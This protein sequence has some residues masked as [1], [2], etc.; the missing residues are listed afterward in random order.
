MDPSQSPSSPVAVGRHLDLRE[1]LGAQLPKLSREDVERVYGSPATLHFDAADLMGRIDTWERAQGRAPEDSASSGTV[2]GFLRAEAL[3]GASTV[4]YNCTSREE[5]GGRRVAWFVPGHTG[6]AALSGS[7]AAAIKSGP[8][9]QLQAIPRVLR[10]AFRA[11]PGRVLVDVDL[12]SAF[13]AAA[14]AVTRDPQLTEDV[15]L[16][17]HQ[18]VGDL[19][20]GSDG[21]PERRRRLGKLVNGTMLCGGTW[22]TIRDAYAEV[23][24]NV[25]ATPDTQWA[26][27]W[28]W[29]RARY[30]VLTAWMDSWHAR[31]LGTRTGLTVTRVDGG[32][33]SFSPAELNGGAAKYTSFHEGAGR[34]LAAYR[35]TLSAIWRAVESPILDRALVLTA[36]R[37]GRDVR[38][39]LPMFDGAL[40]EV[41]QHRGYERAGELRR[42]FND[43][44]RESGVLVRAV[45]KA[46][47]SGWP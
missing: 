26:G 2:V 19:L 27:A 5:H 13:A 34:Q 39:V 8:H 9:Y 17:V 45:A 28:E 22:S 43:A 38:L 41:D 3:R 46:P 20:A 29:W 32:R 12:E 11:Q 25:S 30:N 33:F 36:D 16:G 14:A 15:A 35:S 47:S 18:I 10:P 21:T 24:V 37:A 7:G 42:A 4:F 23:G 1:V 44:A 6:R 40:F 31:C